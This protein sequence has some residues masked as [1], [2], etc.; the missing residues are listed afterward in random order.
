MNGYSKVNAQE[1]LHFKDPPP[2]FFTVKPPSFEL[3]FPAVFNSEIKNQILFFQL[4]SSSKQ[5]MFCRMED[6]LHSRLNVWIKLRTGS[7]EYYR[8]LIALPH[9][10]KSKLID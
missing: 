1:H 4:A 5:P 2:L 9:E 6:K 7:D 8:T 10:K 3:P